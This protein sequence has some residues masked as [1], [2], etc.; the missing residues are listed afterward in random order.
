MNTYTQSQKNQYF[1]SLRHQWRERKK[2]A[3][4]DEKAKA[5][6]AEVQKTNAGQMSYWSFYFTLQDM[7][8]NGYA[9]L[10]YVDCKTFQGW[11]LSGFK[12]KKGEKSK[13]RG[14]VWMSGKN[15]EEED[16]DMILYPKVYNLFHSS[17]VEPLGEIN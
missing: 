12:V 5:I 14:I 15:K 2:Q 10:P 4:G 3:E 16:D 17:Q 13:I 6:F 9:G 11:K 1:A 8:A 7:I